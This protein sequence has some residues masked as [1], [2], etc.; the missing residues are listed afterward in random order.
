MFVASSIFPAVSVIATL[1]GIRAGSRHNND[2][3]VHGAIVVL[4]SS[5]PCFSVA[6]DRRSM[7]KTGW[8]VGPGPLQA[9]PMRGRPMVTA[10]IVLHADLGMGCVKQ[11]P[12]QYLFVMQINSVP[13]IWSCLFL[14]RTDL[15]D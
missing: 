11:G 15:F 3:A 4:D 7:V 2:L 12:V 9:L 13:T 1:I 5:Q 8:K 6:A 14:P 10:S